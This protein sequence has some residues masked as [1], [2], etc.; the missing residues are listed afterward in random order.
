MQRPST[1]FTLIEMLISI[2]LLAFISISIAN[3]FSS[4]I[5]IRNR[6]SERS[7]ISR[8]LHIAMNRIIAD[9]Q[10]SVLFR[11]S[12]PIT[13]VRR[14]V[15]QFIGKE[16]GSFYRL[17]FVTNNKTKFIAKNNES[18]LAEISYFVKRD[19]ALG[20]TK[21]LYRR[22][23]AIVNKTPDKGGVVHRLLDNVATF[24]IRFNKYGDKDI[25]KRDWSTVQSNDERPKLPSAISIT[26]GVYHY[27]PETFENT[28]ENPIT[29][30]TTA[31]FLE[32]AT[33]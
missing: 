28:H 19:A 21:V 7:N 5:D 22:E 27:D 17:D 8:K 29:T 6:L 12:K 26:L 9:L 11:D 13:K 3:M 25:D 16:S 1:G 24:K 14:S 30:F 18:D 2:G 4:S 15:S 23:S 20:K 10:H 33:L 31:V 32:N